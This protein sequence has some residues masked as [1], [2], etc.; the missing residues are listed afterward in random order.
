[1][2]YRRLG[3]VG[4]MLSRATKDAL[5]ALGLVTIIPAPFALFFLVYDQEVY[6]RILS[7]IGWVIWFVPFAFVTSLIASHFDLR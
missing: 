5:I 6:F 2:P 1:M 4:T 3:G 7:Y